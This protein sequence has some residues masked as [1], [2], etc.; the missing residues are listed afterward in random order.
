MTERIKDSLNPTF[1]KGLEIDFH[2]GTFQQLKFIVHAINC[3]DHVDFSELNYLGEAE[4]NLG[5]IIDS[6]G[7]Q[8]VLNLRHREFGR[9]AG[10]TMGQI[11]IHVE[12]LAVSRNTLNFSIR[13]QNLTKKGIFKSPPT[14][15]FLIQRADKNGTFSPVYR[16]DMIESK[17]DPEWKAFS[18]KESVICNGDFKRRLK[19][20]IM[21]HKGLKCDKLIGSTAE[22]TIGELSQHRYSRPMAIL[23]TTGEAALIIQSFSIT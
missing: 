11:V 9:F 18:I 20:D 15:F 4:I 22:F 8:V 12:E 14:T 7:G 10:K 6:L 3:K 23:P 13:G 5:S 16:S 2:F 21:K 19:I 17:Y 1:I